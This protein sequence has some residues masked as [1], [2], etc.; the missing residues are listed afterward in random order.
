MTMMMSPTVS[1]STSAKNSLMRR[2]WKKFNQG[3]ATTADTIAKRTTGHASSRLTVTT[4][5]VKLAMRPRKSSV[6]TSTSS[7]TQERH[8]V[9]TF[10]KIAIFLV[11]SA[12]AVYVTNSKFVLCA[13]TTLKFSRTT[14][15]TP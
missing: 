4:I 13:A 12:R 5:C 10:A 8:S 6:L 1:T 15:G 3:S 11:T 14:K 7:C 9:A 2:N